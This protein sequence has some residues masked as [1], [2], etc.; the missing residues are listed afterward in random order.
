MFRRMNSEEQKE[1]SEYYLPGNYNLLII[2]PCQEKL[3]NM[4]LRVE[5]L[6]NIRKINR[7]KNGK[8]KDVLQFVEGLKYYQ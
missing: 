4:I 7:D 6:K 2:S 3:N 5:Y 1:K 8:I